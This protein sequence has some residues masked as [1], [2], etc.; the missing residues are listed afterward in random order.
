MTGR[1][2]HPS[3]AE[4]FSSSAEAYERG[5]PEYPEEAVRFVQ[6][7]FGLTDGST[8]VDLAAGTGK[9]TRALR[10]TES[11]MVALEPLTEMRQQFRAVL[12][13]IPLVGAIAE[14]LPLRDT[15]VGA[16]VVA[17]AWHWFNSNAAAAEVHRVLHPGGGLAIVYN[18]RD[19]SVDWV[20]ELS[21][22]IDRHRGDTPQYRSGKW[23]EVLDSTPLFGPLRRTDFPYEHA[24]SP[25]LL[26][27]RVLSV[28]FIAQL[29]E[30]RR[31]RVVEAVD[32]LVGRHLGG[33]Q[34]FTLPHRTEVYTTTK[35]ERR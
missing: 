19:E 28:S 26:R 27:D 1:R 22:I 18:R 31:R 13:Q 29:D 17:N 12:P 24:M 8:L 2:I 20:A 3:A 9:L 33:Q 32:E 25:E 23:R 11:W 6:K 35:I 16:V 14:R 10:A 34:E 5:R 4:G 30:S 15:S 21:E 7:T